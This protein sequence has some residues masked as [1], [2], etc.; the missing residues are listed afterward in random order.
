MKLALLS[1]ADCHLCDEAAA[2]LSEM[3]VE[4]ETVDVDADPELARR[5]GEA[6]PVV[7][8]DGEEIARAPIDAPALRRALSSMTGVRG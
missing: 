1:R 2:L 4:F 5:Y 6:I 3:D 8:A 7:L